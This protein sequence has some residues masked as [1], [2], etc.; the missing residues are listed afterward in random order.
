MQPLITET[1]TVEFKYEVYDTTFSALGRELKILLYGNEVLIFNGW[2]QDRHLEDL[3]KC[4]LTPRQ[5]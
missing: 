1:F 3:K 4:G 2:V 5:F